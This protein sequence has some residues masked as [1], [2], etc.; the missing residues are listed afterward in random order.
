[1]AEC[2]LCHQKIGM[3]ARKFTGAAGE[4][5]CVTC[6]LKAQ[7]QQFASRLAYKAKEVEA[8]PKNVEPVRDL[9]V[10]NYLA[11]RLLQSDEPLSTRRS[12]E[13]KELQNR[14]K[15]T[16]ASE[17]MFQRSKI[18]AASRKLIEQLKQS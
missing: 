12:K 1:M 8:Y 9:A 4:A 16:S 3:F 13:M 2:K 7:R 11:E 6:A 18:L 15:N 5:L 17:V 14:T 10:E